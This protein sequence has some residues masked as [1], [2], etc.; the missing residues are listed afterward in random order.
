[1]TGSAGILA[2]L[3]MHKHKGT[4]LQSEFGEWSKYVSAIRYYVNSSKITVTR[5]IIWEVY[6]VSSPCL[7]IYMQLQGWGKDLRKIQ[8]SQYISTHANDNDGA[9]G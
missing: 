6:V 2:C 4:E 8:V 9:A 3:V 5:L 7:H 1:M